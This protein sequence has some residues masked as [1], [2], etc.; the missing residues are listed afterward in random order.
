MRQVLQCLMVF[1]SGKPAFCT[2]LDGHDCAG[3]KQRH[4]TWDFV[5]GDARVVYAIRRAPRPRG[6]HAKR[7]GTGVEAGNVRHDSESYARA[8]GPDARGVSQGGCR[9]DRPGCNQLVASCDEVEH[10]LA[11]GCRF[12]TSLP[13]GRI[14]VEPPTSCNI[15]ANDRNVT[16]SETVVQS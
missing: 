15:I 3:H 6:Q 9:Q 1:G 14:I 5:A 7:R 16:S 2:S 12:V 11:R 10:V 13:D 8:A 4:S